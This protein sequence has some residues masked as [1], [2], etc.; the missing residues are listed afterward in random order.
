MSQAATSSVTEAE[1]AV[2][3]EV[4]AFQEHQA[5]AAKLSHAEEART[6]VSLGT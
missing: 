4:E 2:D 1:P 5:R 6:L 3:P